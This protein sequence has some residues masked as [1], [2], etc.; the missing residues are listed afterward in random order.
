MLGM[1]SLAKILASQEHDRRNR[2]LV[3]IKAKTRLT[4]VMRKVTIDPRSSGPAIKKL[5]S[6]AQ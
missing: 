1:H 5:S 2:A 4:A 3:R 6:G